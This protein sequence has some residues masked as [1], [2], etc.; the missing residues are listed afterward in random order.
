MTKPIRSLEY[1]TYQ[2]LT[3]PTKNTFFI[4]NFFQCDSNTLIELIRENIREFDTKGRTLS[5]TYRRLK[6][7]VNHY[8]QKG[9]HLYI[10]RDPIFKKPIACA[11]L[12]AFQGLP[13][14]EKIGEIRDLV[15]QKKFRHKGL[16]RQLLNQCLIKAKHVGYKRLY[17][18]T[19]K[20]MIIAQKLFTQSGFTP[21]EQLQKKQT[22]A[23]DLPYYYLL[24]DLDSKTFSE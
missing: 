13:L 12:G 17:L 16:G 10:I 18:E 22:E 2:T 7:L 19:S 20:H 5:T 6:N 9:N 11:G 4:E 15:V 8:T 24:K 3:N 1:K 21:V 14:A 23:E